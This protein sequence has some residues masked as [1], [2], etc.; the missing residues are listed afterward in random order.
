MTASRL[1]HRRRTNINDNAYTP[2]SC[3]ND[4]PET[5]AEQAPNIFVDTTANPI[6]PVMSDWIAKF[7]AERML[8]GSDFPFYDVNYERDKVDRL[9]ASD[10]EKSLIAG[11][12]ARRLFDF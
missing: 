10:T 3:P 5:A 7:G 12:N 11:G 1:S 2:R 6:L 9:H 4:H 8:W